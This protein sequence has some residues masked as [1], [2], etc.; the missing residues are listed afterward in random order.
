MCSHHADL[1]HLPAPNLGAAAL[2]GLIKLYRR[3][4][5]PYTMPS[6]KYTPT[7]SRYAMDAVRRYGVFKGSWLATWRI[8]R[9]NPFARGGYD[10]L[11]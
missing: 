8:L 5:S 6:C 1:D 2:I 4:I 10:P 9:C 3:F 11:L 7:C